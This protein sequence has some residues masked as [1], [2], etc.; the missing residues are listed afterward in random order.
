MRYIEYIYLGLAGMSLTF[1]VTE[2]ERLGTMQM[3]FMLLGMGIF[4]FMFAFRRKQRQQMEAYERE[5]MEKIEEE[6]ADWAEDQEKAHEQRHG[7]QSDES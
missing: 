1:L 6:L 4:A 2:Y 3:T 7:A 5:E